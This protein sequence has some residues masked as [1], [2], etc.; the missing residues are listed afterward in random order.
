MVQ[1]FTVPKIRCA[2]C[3]ETITTALTGLRGV[4]ATSVAVPEKEVRVEYDPARVDEARV[5]R[6]LVEAGFPPA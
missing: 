1:V 3:A 2:G 4:I 6:A 5:K